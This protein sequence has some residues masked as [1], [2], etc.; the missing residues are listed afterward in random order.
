M[1]AP[2]LA[3]EFLRPWWLAAI[4]FALALIGLGLRQSYGAGGWVDA[5]DPHLLDHLR[6]DA[7][8]VRPPLPVWLLVAIAVL[9]PLALAGPARPEP[10]VPVARSA[11]AR[12]VVLD[13]SIS[14]YAIDLSPTRMAQARRKVDQLL[15][16]AGDTRAGLVVFAGTA[17]PV[18]PLTRDS[19]TLRALLE[20]L[21]PSVLQHQGSRVDLGLEAA[22]DLLRQGLASAGHVL[23]VTDGVRGAR[24]R[25]AARR[26]AADGHRVSVL[27][28][29]TRRGAPVLLPGGDELR[30][31]SGRPVRAGVD[32]VALRAIAEAG[33][34]RFAWLAENE[35][36]LDWVLGA[37]PAAGVQREQSRSPAWRDLGPWLVLLMLVPAALL[38]RHGWLLALGLAILTPAQE[39]R[40]DWWER[41][42]LRPEQSAERALERADVAAAQASGDWWWRGT[43]LFRDQR[44]GAAADAFAWG[45]DATAHYNRGTA[46]A[47]AGRL[48]E[49]LEALDRALTLEP[50]HADARHNRAVVARALRRRA[51]PA[52]ASAERRRGRRARDGRGASAAATAGHA[53]SG[54][55]GESPRPVGDAASP[56]GGTAAEYRARASVPSGTARSRG[57]DGPARADG[58][59][60]ERPLQRLEDLLLQVADDPAELWRLKF[61][62]GRLGRPPPRPAR[63]D[64]W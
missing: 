24:A 31:L 63:S 59:G 29:G 10:R 61:S 27:A 1:T 32:E 42:W 6:G 41:L 44:Y 20:I 11:Q 46:L 16:R 34:G 56:A 5:C 49:S 60:G 19:T 50:A 37:E 52:S 53:R 55:A 54:N 62:I 13:L 30:D 17:A 45:D 15:T 12:V 26:L 23:V 2:L 18:T 28:V 57:A 21:D 25:N 36:D 33:R 58:P 4:P 7:G 9:G 14:M 48:R 40:A 43:T 35:A 39:A 22:A 3:L 8:S 64:A 38:F 51:P 47:A